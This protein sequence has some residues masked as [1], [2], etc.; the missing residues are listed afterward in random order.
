VRI[1]KRAY[2]ST[3][4]DYN[5]IRE[6]YLNRAGQAG[7]DT[8]AVVPYSEGLPFDK[9]FPELHKQI[10]PNIDTLKSEASLLAAS[11]KTPKEVATI[12]RGKYN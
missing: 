1:G 4:G 11:G 9:L 12:L 3:L 7:L 8:S 10:T 6:S 5:T 2:N